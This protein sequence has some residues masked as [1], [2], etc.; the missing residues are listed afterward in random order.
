ME[1][2]KSNNPKSSR[3]AKLGKTIRLSV[4]KTRKIEKGFRITINESRENYL[5][6]ELG[7][8]KGIKVSYD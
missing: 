4:S 7:K 8:Y 5:S 2:S 1:K 6:K 3:N